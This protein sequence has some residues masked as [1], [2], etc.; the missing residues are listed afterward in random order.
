MSDHDVTQRSGEF[1]PPV[2]LWR[3][4]EIRIA[5]A[6]LVFSGWVFWM[7]TTFARVPPRLSP[8]LMPHEF[9]QFLLYVLLGLTALMVVQ[10]LAHPAERPRTPLPWVTWVSAVIV[11]LFLAVME[12]DLFLAFAVFFIALALLWGERRWQWVVAVGVVM[13]AIIFFGFD[14]I[15][16][17][18][19]PRGLLTSLY[20]D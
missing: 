4:D 5:V 8:G 10:G 1:A 3:R 6:I 19:F 16:E 7:T 20:Y 2:P 11:V 18:R 12:I 13:P 17:V 15:L 9:P 14:H